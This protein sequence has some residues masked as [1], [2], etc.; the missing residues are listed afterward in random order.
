[1]NS[2]K[3]GQVSSRSDLP[4]FLVLSTFSKFRQL[5]L[6]RHSHLSLP[7]DWA[8]FLRFCICGASGSSDPLPL[9][10]LK[11]PGRGLCSGH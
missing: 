3:L 11:V 2:G 1:M 5:V 4:D 10:P 8:I 7:F 6:G 9:P